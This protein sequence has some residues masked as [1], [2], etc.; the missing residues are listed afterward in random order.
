MN[1]ST[2]KLIETCDFISIDTSALMETDTLLDFL[3]RYEDI[4]RS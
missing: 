3:K 2:K 4:Y 1:M